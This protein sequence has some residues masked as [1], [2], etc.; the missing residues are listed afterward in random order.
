MIVTV[1][2]DVPFQIP[3]KLVE[4]ATHLLGLAEAPAIE[5]CSESH[6]T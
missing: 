6:H 4:F 5:T 3:D 1:N 2:L